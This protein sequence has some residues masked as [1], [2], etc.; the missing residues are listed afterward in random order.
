MT[1]VLDEPWVAEA[2]RRFQSDYASV[3][4]NRRVDIVGKKKALLKFGRNVNMASGVLSTIWDTGVANETYVASNLIDSISSSSASDT[5]TIRV[6]GHYYGSDGGLH[7]VIL[8]ATLSGRTPVGD[9]TLVADLYGEY[10]GALARVTRMANL[11]AV[12]LVGDVYIYQSGQTVTAGVPQDLTKVHGKIRGTAGL[13]QSNKCATTVSNEDF[14]IITSVRT[15]VARSQAAFVDFGLEIREPGGVFR[16]R[17]IGNGSRDSGFG[18]IFDNAPHI[19][20]PPN[21]DV[22]VRGTS[23]AASTTG[24]ASFNGILGALI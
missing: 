10:A 2:V 1:N 3:I 6:E 4:A 13:Q 22:R 5:T 7:F 20:A 12:P 16:E 23:S 15:G 18:Q 9:G 21:S 14:Y 8:N 11:S 17:L 24:I 19:I